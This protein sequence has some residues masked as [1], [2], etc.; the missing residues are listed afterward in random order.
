MARRPG[1]VYVIA[2]LQALFV[3]FDLATP[4]L[5]GAFIYYTGSEFLVAYLMGVLDFILIIGFMRG[6]KWAWFFGLIFSGI[7]I[8]NYALSFLSD[9]IALYVLLLFLRLILILCL[10]TRSVREHFN[11]AVT[12]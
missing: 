12:R 2:S 6:S 8:I 9:P 10:R 1:L 7:N 4:F 5:T 3:L 11:V